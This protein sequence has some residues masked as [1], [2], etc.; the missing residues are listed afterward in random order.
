MLIHAAQTAK[1][2]AYLT[3]LVQLFLKV[4]LIK[5]LFIF[6]TITGFEYVTADARRL[7]QQAH[8][9]LDFTQGVDH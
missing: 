2:C 7:Q 6:I 5:S 3:V 9:P 8:M 4:I 1:I